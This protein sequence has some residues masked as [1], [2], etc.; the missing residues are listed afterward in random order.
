MAEAPFDGTPETDANDVDDDDDD[1]GGSGGGG[2][3]A[4]DGHDE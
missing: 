1:A 4:D 3:E 2:C